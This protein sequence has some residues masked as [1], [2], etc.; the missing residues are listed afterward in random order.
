MRN[1]GGTSAGHK[2]AGYIYTPANT[3]AKAIRISPILSRNHNHSGSNPANSGSGPNGTPAEIELSTAIS[4]PGLHPSRGPGADHEHEHDL[5]KGHD[6][7]LEPA[8]V[9]IETEK[10]QR[11]EQGDPRSDFILT[12]DLMRKSRPAA[13]DDDLV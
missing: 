8:G 1:G 9:R 2:S 7:G 12:A 5:K 3:S 4:H 11:I 10:E 6:A 13:D